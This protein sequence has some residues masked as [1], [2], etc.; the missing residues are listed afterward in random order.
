MRLFHLDTRGWFRGED[1]TPHLPVARGRGLARPAPLGALPRGH[2]DRAP[3]ARAARA[4]CSRRAC[5]TSSRIAAPACASTASPASRP[6]ACARRGSSGRR[7]STS[8]RTGTSG[9]TGSSAT[10]RASR[11]GCGSS[12]AALRYLRPLVHPDGRAAVEAA[13]RGPDLEMIELTRSV[14]AARLRVPRAAHV[15]PRRRGARSAGAARAN[16]RHRRGGR[17]PVPIGGCGSSE[18]AAMVRPGR[19]P[20]KAAAEAMAAS[21]LVGSPGLFFCGPKRREQD[22]S[23]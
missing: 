8:R 21:G 22:G 5:G 11:R 12:A 3:H 9:R 13:R 10:G 4:S 23:G 1:K 17:R 14:R 15:R 20:R 18:A 2:E 7:G 19:A 16:P 6:R